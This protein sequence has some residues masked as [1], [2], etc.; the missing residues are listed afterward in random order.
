LFI[1]PQVHLQIKHQVIM[2]HKLLHT[3]SNEL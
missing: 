2:M 3:V 1:Q